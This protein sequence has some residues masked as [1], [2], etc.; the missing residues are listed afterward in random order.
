MSTHFDTLIIG[1]GISG[2][3]AAHYMQTDCPNKT[4][5]ILEGRTS[6]GGTWDLFRYPGIRSDSDMFTFGFAFRPWTHPSAIAP[7]ELI[8][9]YLEA[10]VKEEGIKEHILFEHK[11][12]KATWSSQ[13]ATW[14]LS[15][16]VANTV[17][18]QIF[19][20][21]FLALCT[22]YYD[23]KSGYSP[24]FKGSEAFKGRIVHPQNWTTDID[25]ANQKVIV[26]GS[27]ATAITL[28]PAMAEAAAHV[29]MLQRSPTYIASRP[30]VDGR[31]QW[32]YRNLPKNMAHSIN[33]WL[34]IRM[35]NLFYYYCKNYPEKVKQGLLKGVE[36][37][38]GPDFDID[39]H[40]TPTYKPW[41]QRLCLAPDGDFFKI[42]KSKKASVV[43]DH[44]DTFTEAG[45]LLKSGKLL[46]ADLI[47]T[48]TGLNAVA[49]TNFDIEVDGKL[50]DFSEKISYR[51]AMY[52][53]IPNMSLAFGYTNASWTLK[54]DLVHQYI[55]RLINYMD[56]KD[57]KQCCPRQ[58]DPTLVL[59][60]A[61]D[62]TPGYIQR[63]I[64]Q[65]PKTGTKEPWKLKQSYYYDKKVLTKQSL[66]DGVIEFK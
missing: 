54:I 46:E 14:T 50:V 60:P 53:D 66:N 57:Y 47:V 17:E 61:M 39:T 36:Q 45:I 51:G 48:A 38:L 3:S 44:I 4:Y 52:N 41:D 20:C 24:E 6:I 9:D 18:P 33:R 13:T 11:V 15:V 27:G 5:A 23:Y 12:N 30:A 19:T 10:T 49:V 8:M 28:I 64:D 31:A 65:L 16:A 59:A 34:K 1:A 7:R 43:T 2:I 40:F 37:Y 22:G 35:Q 62:F 29:T 21:S 56:K 58:N 55:C 42:I 32:L 26:I 25:Y 63:I